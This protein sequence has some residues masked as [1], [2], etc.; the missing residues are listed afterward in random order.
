MPDLDTEEEDRPN[1]FKR[2]E[3]HIQ[4]RV[5]SGLFELVPLIVTILVLLYLV[6]VADGF[7]RERSFV[8]DQPL[9]L[10]WSWVDHLGGGLLSDRRARS[11]KTWASLPKI[12]QLDHDLHPS[13]QD[14]LWRDTASNGVSWFT[15][16]LQQ[17][18]I[19]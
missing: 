13:S 15:G 14:T 12:Y 10:S 6:D 5:I 9:G 1:I 11:F 18:R 16:E 4:G 3:S 19:H 8:K 7:F 17:G 2:V